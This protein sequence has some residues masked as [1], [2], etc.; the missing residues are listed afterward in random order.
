MQ[1]SKEGQIVSTPIISKDGEVLGYN[2]K[3][4]PATTVAREE[5]AAMLKAASLFGFDP[6]SRSRLTTGEAAE[7]EDPFAKFMQGL[8]AEDLANDEE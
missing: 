8:G 3:R 1:V 2:H 4:H 6:S 5:R 7:A